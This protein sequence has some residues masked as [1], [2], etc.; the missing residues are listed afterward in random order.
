MFGL[1]CGLFYLC[2][3]WGESC[4]CIYVFVEIEVEIGILGGECYVSVVLFGVDYFYGD[5]WLWIYVIIIYGEKIV[6]KIV[7]FCVL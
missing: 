4:G 7:F 2:S 5:I 6:F 3:G 1:F